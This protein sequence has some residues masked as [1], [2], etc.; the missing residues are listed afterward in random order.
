MY[1]GKE[2]R[3]HDADATAKFVI[4]DAKLVKFIKKKIYLAF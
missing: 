3:I 2:L 1:N 4:I